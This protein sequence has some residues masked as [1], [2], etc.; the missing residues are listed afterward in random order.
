M[1]GISIFN[2]RN[3]EPEDA[4]FA[5]IL[6]KNKN[7]FGVSADIKFIPGNDQIY[8]AFAADVSQGV[9]ADLIEVLR[10]TKVLLY[11]GQNDVVVN[12]PGVLQYINSL[13]WEN[14]NQ[15]KRATKQVWTIANEVVGWAK[16][17]GNLWFVLVNGAGHMVPTD[18]PISS[19]VMMGHFLNDEHDWN[20]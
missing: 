5:D 19:F 6:E 1:G 2:F 9:T 14:L 3:Y 8:T 10:R 13:Q 4:S 16:V 17:A 12:T 20:L 7:V 15:W 18:Q 11:N